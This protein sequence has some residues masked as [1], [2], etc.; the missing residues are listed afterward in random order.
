MKSLEQQFKHIRNIAILFFCSIVTVASIGL[1]NLINTQYQTMLVAD[2][3]LV[4][5]SIKKTLGQYPSGLSRQLLQDVE[6]D[7][8]SRIGFNRLDFK[9]IHPKEHHNL[10]IVEE[11]FV[12]T[13][14]NGETT[15]LIAHYH[16]L[17]GFSFHIWTLM[18]L[19]LILTSVLIAIVL[20]L[21]RLNKIVVEPIKTISTCIKNGQSDKLRRKQF[22]YSEYK[23]LK[24]AHLDQYNHIKKL[25]EGLQEEVERQTKEIK[26]K[27]RKLAR[28]TKKA[29]AAT[30]AKSLFLSNMSHEIRTPLNAIMS[31]VELLLTE[32]YSKR[33]QNE[34]IK[35]VWTAS[36]A[37]KEIIQDILDVSKIEAG[38]YSLNEEVADIS[39]L[40]QKV[41]DIFD[42]AYAEK[43][44]NLTV[45]NSLPRTSVIADEGKLLQVLINLVGNSLK[46]TD[47]GGCTVE[48]L[49][50]RDRKKAI[51]IQ[52]NV[53]DTGIGIKK[54]D[55][56][57]LFKD[58]SQLENTL[59]KKG[60]GTGL[61]LSIIKKIV[62]LMK[63]KIKLDST[64]GEGS[65]F[66]ITL[67]L[68]KAPIETQVEA[69]SKVKPVNLDK[70]RV[71]CAEDDQ[72]NQYFLN[73][74]IQKIN[75]KI[76]LS[77]AQ[78]GKEAVD[79][80]KK[81]PKQIDLIL[82]D[83]H[84]PEMDGFEAARQIRSFEE[85]AG[86]K[87]PLVAL[88]ANILEETKV[89]CLEL[90]MDDVLVKPIELKALQGV[91][92]RYSPDA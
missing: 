54:E 59:T 79:F 2:Q 51:D 10:G 28:K 89:K 19:I 5:A 18:G 60:V 37:L 22:D 7:L 53:S 82:M 32:S 56:K 44:L 34:V 50:K 72:M 68:L 39:S 12:F 25:N 6:D 73:E 8:A 58:F 36:A 35:Q 67:S 41:T 74:F 27:N 86:I 46:F 61:G 49:L 66:S 63:G 9:A 75:P 16:I 13:H 48:L 88:T 81:A 15:E 26:E 83:L 1:L 87:T 29:N 55:L 64:Y 80:Y 57:K 65:T 31:G 52:I 43:G 78:N 69:V 3:Y 38:N 20:L 47:E 23:S 62:T 91:L 70:L 42:G 45:H 92:E 77:F 11:G 4:Q 33:K 21:K 17:D 40:G 71:L 14:E 84:M 85:E 30:K 90:G 76:S 24:Q